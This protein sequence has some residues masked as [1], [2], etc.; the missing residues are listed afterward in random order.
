MLV[1]LSLFANLVEAEE[2][3]TRVMFDHYKCLPMLELKMRNNY[4]PPKSTPSDVLADVVVDKCNIKAEPFLAKCSLI[5]V[6]F[7]QPAQVQANLSN[8]NV[9][10]VQLLVDMLLLE[11]VDSIDT[12]SV[13]DASSTKKEAI[14][15][16]ALCTRQALR[17]QENSDP[18]L[19]IAELV[20]SSHFCLLLHTLDV[21]LGKSASGSKVQNL[22]PRGN[23]WLP[24]RVLQAYI[25]LQGQV[26]DHIQLSLPAF[27]SP[28]LDLW[29]NQIF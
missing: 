19:P 29:K 26:S 18:N 22:L 3:S 4:L 16:E 24:M 15:S 17:D 8:C 10:L 5:P 14:G 12:I 11:M 27:L 20:L 13:T 9:S 23:W 21:A 1:N 25:A 2:M 7:P 6:L 28:S